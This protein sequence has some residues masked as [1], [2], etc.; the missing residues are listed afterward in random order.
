MIP[1]FYSKTS[2]FPLMFFSISLLYSC[3]IY[4]PLC[5]WLSTNIQPYII[6]FIWSI[7]ISLSVSLYEQL[8]VFFIADAINSIVRI[9]CFNYSLSILFD[10]IRFINFDFAFVI[11]YTHIPPAPRCTLTFNFPNDCSTCVFFIFLLIPC[12]NIIIG[13]LCPFNKTRTVRATRS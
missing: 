8:N 7:S 9:F 6:Q 13:H 3:D 4:T 10:F 12:D 2:V 1:F 11:I 5:M